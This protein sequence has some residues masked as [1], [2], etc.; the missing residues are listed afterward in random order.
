M[1]ASEAASGKKLSAEQAELVE[2]MQSI[3]IYEF[4]ATEMTNMDQKSAYV[5]MSVSGRTMVLESKDQQGNPARTTV[6]VSGD[7]MT[8]ELKGDD[9]V[10]QRLH[11]KRKK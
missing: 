5:V 4:T 8:M 10:L 9:G 3:F 2:A 11:L 7:T 6:T 1:A